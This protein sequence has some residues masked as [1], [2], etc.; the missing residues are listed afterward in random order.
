MKQILYIKGSTS[1]DVRLRKCLEYLVEANIP[2]SFVGWAR[3]G[4]GSELNGVNHSYIFAGGGRNNKSVMLYYPFWIL[5]VFFFFLFKR[6]LN[7]YNIIAINFDV[8][9][10][11]YLASCI[12]NFDFMYE[13]YDEFAIS[14]KFPNWIKRLLKSIDNK[15][16]QSAKII[17]QVDENRVVAHENKTIVIQNSPFDYYEGKGR[18]YEKV[19]HRFAA[20]GL[21]NNSRGLEQILAFAERFANIEVLMVGEIN[22]KKINAKA[23]AMP[24]VI[25]REFMAQSELFSLMENC[26]GIF[27]L[28][29]PIIEINR[30]AASN[31]VYDAMMMGI[32]VITNKEVINS[33]FIR[34]NNT[35]YVVSYE[36]NESWGFLANSTFIEEAKKMGENSRELY[37]SKF[38]FSE[39]LRKRLF[40]YLS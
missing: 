34:S 28:Y 17:I 27:S 9:F 2:V 24:N 29:N 33:E 21:L 36:F 30:L 26:C 15:I 4:K 19:K 39:L 22:D 23:E 6:K 3:E 1:R 8:A 7:S 10:P 35:G 16:M 20:T 12:R 37:L 40:P 11:L 14:Y 5:R 31:K 38:V 13:I 25:R 32:P 18:S